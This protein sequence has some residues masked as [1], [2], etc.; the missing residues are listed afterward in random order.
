M[1]RPNPTIH[2]LEERS[3]IKSK[4]TKIQLNE[5]TALPQIPQIQREKKATQTQEAFG[6]SKRG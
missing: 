5:I 1:S 3:V 4:G 6:F 2:G